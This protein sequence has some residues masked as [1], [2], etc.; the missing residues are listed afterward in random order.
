MA[1]SELKG[2]AIITRGH[3]KEGKWKIEDIHVRPLKENELL[4][5]M[6]ASGI[7]HT[8]VILGDNADNIGGYPRVMGHEG[9]YVQIPIN[10]VVDSRC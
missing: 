9:S 3:H 1:T 5:Q 6:V 4:V 8:D 7:C 10:I 2:R